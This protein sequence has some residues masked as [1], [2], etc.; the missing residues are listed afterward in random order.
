[1]ALQLVETRAFDGA[2][3]NVDDITCVICVHAS[4]GFVNISD[5][6]EEFCVRVDRTRVWF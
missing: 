6:P 1:M 5:T 2:V 4:G 3:E